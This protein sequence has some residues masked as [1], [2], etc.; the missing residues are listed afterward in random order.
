MRASTFSEYLI[1]GSYVELYNEDIRDLLAPTGGGAAAAAANLG[2]MGA[3]KHG[4]QGQTEVAGLV[5]EAVA[6]QEDVLELLRRAQAARSVATTK[7][8]ARSSRS[9]AVFMLRVDAAHAASGQTRV[10]NLVLVDLAGSERLD[11]SGAQGE[12]LKEA[13]AINKSLS[14]LGNVIMALG[15]KQK[16]VP[17]RDSTLTYL[18]QNCLGGESK[19]LMMVNVSPCTEHTPETLCSLR[20][21]QKVNATEVG[22]AKKHGSA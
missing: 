9:H 3:V 18:L 6:C 5:G 11:Q 15:K 17:F 13:L 12:Q 2:G 10:G 4:V 1:R 20:F 8:N 16:H 14:S 22:V 19:C 21:A 7:M